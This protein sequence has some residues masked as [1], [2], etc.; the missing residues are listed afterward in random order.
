MHAKYFPLFLILALVTIPAG[1]NR[2]QQAPGSSESV[3]ASKNP[4]NTAVKEKKAVPF[5]GTLKAMDVKAGTFVIGQRTFEVN[6]TTRISKA[7]QPAHLQDARI[8]DLLTGTYR[9]AADQKLLAAS[10]YIGGKGS[11]KPKAKE[12][13]S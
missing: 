12:G 1:L 8:G 3:L 11:G 10:V 4:V 2:A 7:G 13:K 5:H 9:K 6:T